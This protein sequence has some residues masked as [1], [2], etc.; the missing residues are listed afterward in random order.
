M[1]VCLG[2]EATPSSS[3]VFLVTRWIQDCL[4]SVWGPH[5]S[6]TGY[7][8][9]IKCGMLHSHDFSLHTGVDVQ[10]RQKVNKLRCLSLKSV[11]DR[12]RWK[13]RRLPHAF[14]VHDYQM[15]RLFHF[16]VSDHKCNS[17]KAH[18]LCYLSV[19]EIR[20]QK[21]VMPDYTWG[22]SRAEFLLED[23]KLGDSGPCHF[24]FLEASCIPRFM[25]PFSIFKTS[26]IV[27]KTLRTPSHYI[28]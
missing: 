13:W 15:A 4:R 17:W 1:R 28:V 20:S 26:K 27:M 21:W 14:R 16:T 7:M 2:G 24:Q 10:N 12:I 23:L 19:L 6:H 11:G 3:E 5:W 22:L 9:W 8:I 25:V 18:I